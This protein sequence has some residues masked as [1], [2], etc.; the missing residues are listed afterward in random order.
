MIPA[1]SL[2]NQA[3]YNCHYPTESTLMGLELAMLSV[4]SE[5]PSKSKLSLGYS[6]I[7]A[8]SH[9]PGQKCHCRRG[10]ESCLLWGSGLQAVLLITNCL[11]EGGG[12]PEGRGCSSCSLSLIKTYCSCHLDMYLSVNCFVDVPEHALYEPSCRP[13]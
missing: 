10:L 3:I 4:P 5:G 11:T 8:L 12:R 6:A 7:K 13:P 9:G 2:R 1:N